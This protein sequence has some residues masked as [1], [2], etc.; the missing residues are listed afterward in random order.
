MTIKEM[1]DQLRRATET[2]L[3][4]TAYFQDPY[5]AAALR[6]VKE[7]VIVQRRL[8][9]FS[10]EDVEEIVLFTLDLLEVPENFTGVLLGRKCT[11]YLVDRA[12]EDLLKD[13]QWHNQIEHIKTIKNSFSE[14]V[15]EWYAVL[16][17]AKIEKS[18]RRLKKSDSL[19]LSF[20]VTAIYEAGIQYTKNKTRKHY[21]K[22]DFE[23]NLYYALAY[24]FHKKLKRRLRQ[25]KK[26]SSRKRVE[27]VARYAYEFA[28][29]AVRTSKDLVPGDYP[30]ELRSDMLEN[31]RKAGRNRKPDVE[32]TV[33]QLE[34]DFDN[35]WKGNKVST[36]T[37]TV[38]R[39]T[40]FDDEPGDLDV[41]DG[42]TDEK[43]WKVKNR[44]EVGLKGSDE[45]N[46]LG[47]PPLEL[48]KGYDPFPDDSDKGRKRGHLSSTY[49]S[50]FWDFRNLQLKVY[51]FLY[52]AIYA[53]EPSCEDRL[54]IL[55][56]MILMHT[57]VNV[58]AL[59]DL[60]YI[61][62]FSN[63]SEDPD[64][65]VLSK[66]GDMYYLLVPSFVEH[67]GE[68]PASCRKTAKRTYVPIPD[69]I[70]SFLPEQLEDGQRIFLNYA[71]L[72][73]GNRVRRKPF[74]DQVK[75]FLNEINANYAIRKKVPD[76]YQQGI[77]LTPFNIAY[78][79]FSL[80]AELCGLN[81]II[82]CH[83]S[84]KDHRNQLGPQLYYLYITHKQ[85]VEEYLHSFY[86]VHHLIQHELHVASLEG[87][88]RTRNIPEPLKNADPIIVNSSLNGY[89][90]YVSVGAAYIR[91]RLAKLAESVENAENFVVFHNRYVAYT[92]LV[93]QLATTLRP[94]ADPELYWHHLN[95]SMLVV[96]DKASARWLEERVV[97]LNDRT[98]Q[99]LESLRNGWRIVEKD[100]L[101]KLC[102]SFQ[103]NFTEKIF[104]TIAEDGTVQPFNFDVI[105]NIFNSIGS[106]FDV[107]PNVM[108]HFTPTYLYGRGVRHELLAVLMGHVRSGREIGCVASTMVLAE[109]AKVIIPLLDQMFDELGIK[110]LEY[111]HE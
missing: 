37:V 111:N 75:F 54:I 96:S 12:F 35:F 9:C 10:E 7:R 74:L 50:H 8:S 57:G 70:A 15:E 89:G 48:M 42:G 107:P 29:D 81:P 110:A 18:E 90:S 22:E 67:A 72:D 39:R 55:Y 36:K 40:R 59:C 64:A 97:I 17:E 51:A 28:S 83:I 91:D 98:R 27:E 5:S 77:N 82:A 63:S 41:P 103:N 46:M 71:I 23:P 80:Y 11:S 6:D 65:M 38:K 4:G 14:V 31:Y 109:V 24:T 56:L 33:R 88:I 85:L 93:T 61:Y 45:D 47:E 25:Y 99:L 102:I 58:Y 68:Q 87:R 92:Y 101:R 43:Q 94:H 32:K 76:Q 20:H 30:R 100:K 66:M 62:E 73:D 1:L 52:E 108:R 95:K 49:V 16:E 79:F 26:Y 106:D 104:F 69:E 78:S 53:Q 60:I 86:R 34:T 3:V 21:K 19:M 2:Q 84:G 13:D 44:Q 105:K